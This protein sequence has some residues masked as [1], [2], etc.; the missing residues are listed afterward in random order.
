MGIYLNT[1]LPSPHQQSKVC[2]HDVP[3]NNLREHP[4]DSFCVPYSAKC[5]KGL[6]GFQKLHVRHS[7]V[8]FFSSGLEIYAL[9]LRQTPGE[10]EG[11]RS[12]LQNTEFHPGSR[13][14]ACCRSPA[15]AVEGGGSELG[16]GLSGCILCQ[17]HGQALKRHSHSHFLKILCCCY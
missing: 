3:L 10:G 9:T 4:V 2:F 15:V 6:V 11:W 14:L 7:W 13:C 8:S 16:M 1:A 12:P 5:P 17:R